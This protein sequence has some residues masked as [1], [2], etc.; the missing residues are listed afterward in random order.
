MLNKEQRLEAASQDM[1]DSMLGF[2]TPTLWRPESSTLKN[3]FKLCKYVTFTVNDKPNL[4]S[5]LPLLFNIALE[6]RNK[7]DYSDGNTNG[8]VLV[9]SISVDSVAESAQEFYKS[10]NTDAKSVCVEVSF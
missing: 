6:I 7:S 8:Y 9:T 10:T 5:L 3:T 1:L 4:E 2:G